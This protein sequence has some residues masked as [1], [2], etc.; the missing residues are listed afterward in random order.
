M[1]EFKSRQV[2]TKEELEKA[3]ELEKQQREIE[4]NLKL[5]WDAKTRRNKE[6]ILLCYK[7]GGELT[8]L[9]K[10]AFFAIDE[11]TIPE[12]T[13]LLLYHVAKEY[14]EKGNISEFEEYKERYIKKSD[15][16]YF[17]DKI[18]EKWAK[19]PRDKGVER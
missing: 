14:L 4:H 18:S 1:N 9:E 8:D 12:G 10:E 15:K 16:P 11:S 19:D 7:N 13:Y 2:P 6:L 3:K 5:M 17:M